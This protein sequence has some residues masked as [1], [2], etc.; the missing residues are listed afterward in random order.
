MLSLFEFF[1]KS[2]Q[3]LFIEYRKF[4]IKYS[5]SLISINEGRKEIAQ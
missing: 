1:D 4:I 5:A 2:L 3:D